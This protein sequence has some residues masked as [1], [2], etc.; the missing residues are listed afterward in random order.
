MSGNVSTHISVDY[1]RCRDNRLDPQLS[2]MAVMFK[3]EFA[4]IVS[5]E[6]CFILDTRDFMK[7]TFYSGYSTDGSRDAFVTFRLDSY[8]CRTH[9]EVFFT[10][11][12]SLCLK[13]LVELA[14]SKDEHLDLQ[15]YT[16]G[17]FTIRTQLVSRLTARGTG[18]P[19]LT[20]K[21]R[22]LTFVFSNSEQ[23]LEFSM[24][25]RDSVHFKKSLARLAVIERL[26]S[27]PSTDL[28]DIALAYVFT[29]DMG[30]EGDELHSYFTDISDDLLESVV[31]SG[32]DVHS[33]SM[34][35]AMQR[36]CTALFIPLS[37]MQRFNKAT[38]LNAFKRLLL[39]DI[40]A[41]EY[42]TI[43]CISKVE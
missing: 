30:F 13:Q 27:Q 4:W 39:Q 18:W 28:F 25:E 34:R 40:D 23:L 9:K 37:T 32:Y 12:D 22:L 7:M 24:D 2:A 26:M 14:L 15:S 41:I 38:L 31:S 6:Q 16:D 29:N 5:F 19:I 17:Q 43:I 21:H 10:L 35:Q 42:D 36:V 3:P 20:S 11:Q 33:R 8:G 1:K